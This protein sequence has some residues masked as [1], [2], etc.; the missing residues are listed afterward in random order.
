M[1][2]LKAP[3]LIVENLRALIGARRVNARDVAQWCGHK[4]PWISKIL[5]GERG[6]PLDDLD[7]IA[8]F[9][10]IEVWQLFAPGISAFLERR[11]AERRCGADR[12]TGK[13]RRKA[14]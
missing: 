4:P 12:R 5:S 8:D 7:K 14:T 6:V 1:R 9:F 2:R 11:R 13:D 3:F 10:G